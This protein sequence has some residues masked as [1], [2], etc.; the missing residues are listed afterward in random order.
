MKV[1]A[2]YRWWEHSQK[3]LLAL[4]FA[5]FGGVIIAKLGI[6]GAPLLLGLP[7]F[8]GFVFF[9]FKYPK[10]G[11][12]A[13]LF[14]SFWL[15][16]LDRYLSGPIPYGL[17]IDLLL[18]FTFLVL[19][20]KKWKKLDMSPSYNDVV[21]LMFVW[22]VYVVLELA[23]PLASSFLAWFYSMRGVALYQLLCFGLAFTLLNTRKDFYRF[24]NLWLILSVIG[25]FWAMKQSFLGLDSF[26][27][28][29]LYAGAYET[30]LLFGKLRHFSYYFDAGTYGASMGHT[31]ILAGILFLGP[32]S[33]KRRILYLLVAL[34]SFYGLMLSGTRGALAVP[35]IG[36]ILFLIMTKNT[37]L[38]ITGGGILL[39]GF[40]FLKYTTIAQ[41]NY[42]VQRLRSALDPDDPSLQVRLQNRAALSNYLRDK[43]FGTGLGTAGYW[44]KRFSP[45]TWMANFETD[46]LYTRIRAE[47]GRV[48]HTLFVWM[49]IYIL[50]RGVL[51]VWKLKNE[52]R[53]YLAMAVLAGYAGIL[54]AN[55][56]NS[57]M[58][59]FPITLT[60]FISIAFV[61]SMPY[62]DEE[63]NYRLPAEKKKKLLK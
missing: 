21:L 40:V 51:I 58:S 25:V 9:F 28:T 39:A 1:A 11:L 24:L 60:T 45:N 43:P 55:Y 62:W 32:F 31:T 18:F 19:I 13:A 27:E 5:L 50:I 30:H 35:G 4:V 59:Q 63:G 49:W 61:F 26:E 36:G 10:L 53:R 2:L 8:G 7:L 6:A 41:S 52:E 17:G 44:G 15:A 46:G 47:T 23:N 56:G 57:V 37:R 22:M 20:L 14:L 42:N 54:V 29:W 33:L 16:T 38:L 34:L 3:Y 48:G 12:Y